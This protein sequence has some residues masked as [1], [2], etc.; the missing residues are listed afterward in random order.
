MRHFSIKEAQALIPDLEEIFSNVLRIREQ[1]AAKARIIRKLDAE[2]SPENVPQMAIERA[3]LQ[4]LSNSMNG[5]LKKVVDL[6]GLPKGLDPV[7]VDFP[8]LMDNKEVYLC[9]KMGDKEIRHRHAA[10]ENCS[11]RSPIPES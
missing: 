8:Y 6:G 1:A 4:F 11:S 5:W 3:Q 9:W 10:S 2:D 7:M